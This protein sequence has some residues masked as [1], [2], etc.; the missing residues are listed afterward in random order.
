MKSVLDLSLRYKLP[1]WGSILIVTTTLVV[2]GS[3]MLRAYEDVRADLLASSTNLS[4]R[5]AEILFVPLQEDD[6]WRAFEIINSPLV[7][8]NIKEVLLPK[9][10]VVLDNELRVFVSTRPKVI[11]I[12]ASIEQ[13]SPEY[14]ALA[15]RISSPQDANAQSFNMQ[16]GKNIFIAS[17][18][19]NEGHRYGTLVVIHSK[20]VLV[21]RFLGIA[22]RGG[23]VGLLVL[24]LLLPINWYWGQRM[25]RPLVMLAEQMKEIDQGS[26]RDMDQKIYPYHDEL[27]QLFSAYWRMLQE[28]EA[29]EALEQQIIHSERLAAVGRLA[30]GVAH[31]INNPLGGM[32]TAIDTLKN[33]GE[34]D[35]RTAKTISLIERGLTQ[36]K[37]TVGALLV[38][39]RIKSRDL[40]P[41][42]FEDIRSLVIPQAQKKAITFDW[43]SSIA[44]PLPLQANPVRQLLINLL[45]NAIQAAQH[46]GLVNCS[47]DATDN[48][49]RLSVENDGKQMTDEQTA[50]LYEPFSP[51]TEKG[52]GLGLWVTYQIVQ[53]L[54]GSINL[55]RNS[56]R[57]RFFVT[58]PFSGSTSA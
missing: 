2:S 14:A 7:D 48:E 52:Q 35:S 37:E 24:G 51:L 5:L 19:V 46:K 54:G 57:M 4:Y 53:Q 17:P 3:L 55:D 15:K 9:T 45:L 23:V 13:L 21:P 8:S 18:I 47:I 56:G 27:G 43:R 42:D 50:H 39:A 44:E 34:I 26:V 11:P 31:E 22:Q 32:L 10:I 25:S 29:K 16:D 28:K 20:D 49:L 30:A 12:Q 33:H 6:V 38:E 41:H 1:L 36:I 40:E 58:L